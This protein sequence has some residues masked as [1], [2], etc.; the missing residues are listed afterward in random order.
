M[1]NKIP[2]A[3]TI[4]GS[5]SGG[6]AGIQADLKTFSALGVHGAT[7]IACLTAQNPARVLAVE[8]CPPDLLRR[9]LEA[10]F[11]EI[12]PSAIKTGMLYSPENIR[13]ASNFLKD[14]KMPLIVDPV[15]I[16]TSG[17]TLLRAG[18]LEVLK[19]KLLPL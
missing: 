15:M 11:Q 12:S 3:L 18:A 13:V 16:S 1:F 19:E 17:A 14:K 6:G 7:V 4:A 5:D 2:V 9:Q 8:P 10:V